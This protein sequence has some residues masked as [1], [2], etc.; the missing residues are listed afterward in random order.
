LPGESFEAQ[1]EGLSSVCRLII[2]DHRG[3]GASD[4]GSGPSTMEQL[5]DDALSVLNA[6]KIDRAVIAGISM[7]GY[8]AMALTRLDPGRVRGLLL[9]DTQMSPDDAAGKQ[10][11][12]ETALAIEAKGASHLIETL[13]PRL[14]SASA[15]AALK[16][17]LADWTRSANPTGLAAAVRGMALRTD[18]RDILARFHGPACIIVGSEDTIT[19][20]ERA[21]AMADLISGSTLETIAGAGHLAPLEAPDRFNAIAKTFLRSLD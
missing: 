2:P 14:T 18:S 8:A 21:K 19:P 6:L 20:P 10:K 16:S 13:L 17:R 12:E 15:P 9:I 1:I 5:A 11:R 4:P 7:G 3:F